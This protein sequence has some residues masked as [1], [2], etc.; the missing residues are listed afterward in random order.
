MC[1]Q[2]KFFQRFGES[3]QPGSSRSRVFEMLKEDEREPYIQHY[4]NMSRK[5]SSKEDI[6]N[7]QVTKMKQQIDSYAAQ[8]NY[9]YQIYKRMNPSL[10]CSPFLNLQHPLSEKVIKFRLGSHKL[11]IETG[12]WKGLERKDRLCN[13]CKVLGDEDHFVFDCTEIR[14][15][16]LVLPGNLSE[17]WQHPN[18]FTLTT[19]LM[20]LDLL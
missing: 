5:Y 4:V 14:R 7:E 11:P 2:F 19:R 15:D 9:K 8:G 10:E 6:Y 18:V 17:I 20:D 1:R 13:E 12:R 3:I 16:D